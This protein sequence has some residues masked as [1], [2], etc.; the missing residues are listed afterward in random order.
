MLALFAVER[1]EISFLCFS[2]LNARITYMYSERHIKMAEDITSAMVRILSTQKLYDVKCNSWVASFSAPRT[3]IGIF[4]MFLHLF[5][6]TEIPSSFLSLFSFLDGEDTEDW[7]NILCK[8]WQN[9]LNSNKKYAS[10]NALVWILISFA[11]AS[12]SRKFPKHCLSST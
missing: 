5:V 7:N 8:I 6:V 10:R 4:R 1:H 11:Y 9:M 3:N 12:P 2:L